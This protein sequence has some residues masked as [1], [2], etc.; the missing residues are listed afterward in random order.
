M[1]EKGEEALEQEV[2]F[3]PRLAFFF[4]KEKGMAANTA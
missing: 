2:S 3:W 1:W 4:T